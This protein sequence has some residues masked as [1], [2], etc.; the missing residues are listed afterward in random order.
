MRLRGYKSRE[1]SRNGD[2]G[3]I[4]VAYGRMATVCREDDLVREIA[5]KK[6]FAEG[7]MPRLEHRVDDNFVFLVRQELQLTLGHTNPQLS[8]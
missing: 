1:E 6:I 3:K 7:Q 8:L 5:R 2:A 4:V